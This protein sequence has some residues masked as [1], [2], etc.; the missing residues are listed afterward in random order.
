MKKKSVDDILAELQQA[1]DDATE[2]DLQRWRQ[3][4]TGAPLAACENASLTPANVAEAL[5]T[6]VKNRAAIKYLFSILL[7]CCVKK[8]SK[9][10]RMSALVWK[11]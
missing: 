8:L 9:P 2:T 4:L 1:I 6:I 3:K 7:T 5:E 11:I 10:T